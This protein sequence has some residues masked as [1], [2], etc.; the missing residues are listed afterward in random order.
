VEVEPEIFRSTMKLRDLKTE[1]SDYKGKIRYSQAAS[2]LGLDIRYLFPISEPGNI[3]ANMEYRTSYYQIRSK[4][5]GYLDFLYIPWL[6]S[7]R[8]LGYAYEDE[9]FISRKPQLCCGS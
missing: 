7:L 6:K 8:T 4:V 5:W 9:L 1:I 3:I 2:G